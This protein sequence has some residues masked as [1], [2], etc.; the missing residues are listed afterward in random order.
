MNTN[1][2]VAFAYFSN[3]KF[4][5]WYSGTFGGCSKT[6]PKLYNDTESQKQVI[7]TNFQRKLKDINETSFD[8]EKEKTVGLEAIWL[9]R[10]D[11]E[12]E[13]RG[14][15][16][17]LRIVETPFYDGPNPDFDKKVWKRYRKLHDKVFKRELKE[18]N[19]PS[20]PSKERLKFVKEFDERYPFLNAR[21]NNWISIKDYSEVKEW[22]SNEPT[23]FKETLTK[24]KI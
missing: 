8:E 3:D 12:D 22:A 5:G 4:L 16:V 10:F 13:L 9:F 2:S 20:G 24:Y 14:K 19:L 7:T 17:E 11:S 18:Q 6:S 23:E 1:K 21:A 15:D